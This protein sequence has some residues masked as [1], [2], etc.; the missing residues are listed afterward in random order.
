MAAKGCQGSDKT[1]ENGEVM[2][3]A[4]D[5]CVARSARNGAPSR[6]GGFKACYRIIRLKDLREIETHTAASMIHE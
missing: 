3:M 5:E 4:G 2:M 6:D 1:S